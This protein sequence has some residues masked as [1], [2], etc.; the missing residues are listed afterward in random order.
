MFHC[1]RFEIWQHTLWHQAYIKWEHTPQVRTF[2]WLMR[3]CFAHHSRRLCLSLSFDNYISLADRNDSS[4]NC[5]SPNISSRQQKR[6][7]TDEDRNSKMELATSFLICQAT[8]QNDSANA[9]D[10]FVPT[11][12]D[13]VFAFIAL[14]LMAVFAIVIGSFRS[15]SYHENGV[16]QEVSSDFEP[17]RILNWI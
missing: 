17:D 5:R 12:G 14:D 2:F 1:R 6:H 11:A 7:A 4:N 15:V 8:T 9:T 13:E 16:T 3:R 10:R